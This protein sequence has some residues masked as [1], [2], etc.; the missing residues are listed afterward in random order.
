MTAKTIA[1]SA[2]LAA[3]S[4]ILARLIVPMPNAYTRF[5]LEAAP[6]FLAGV[7]FG[8]VAGSM[9]GFVADLVGTLFSGF[10][11]NP[12]LCLPPILY[13]LAGGLFRKR[14]AG[15]KWMPWLA[16]GLFLPTAFG[17]VLWQSVPLSYFYMYDSR[18]AG[19]FMQG[20]VF[21]LT[22]RGIQFALTYCANLLL[23]AVLISSRIFQHLGLLPKGR[24]PG[25]I[26]DDLDAINYIHSISWKGSVPGLERTRELLR[27]MGDP[28]DRL[29]YIHVAGTNGKGS[30]CAMLAS[31]LHCAGYKVGM[32]TSPYIYRFHERM[33]IDGEPISPEELAEIT[34]QIRPLAESMADTPTEFELVSCIA[35]S[36]FAR[37]G[38]DIVVLE[39]GMGGELDSTNVIS[40]PEVA[41]IT[42]IGLDH[43]EYLGDTVEKIARTKAGICKQG[44]NVVLYRG[45]H[46]VETVIEQICRERGCTLRKAD[47]DSLRSISRDLSGQ[48]FDCGSKK[49]L[50]LPLLGEHQL[51]NA[52]V[53]LTVT[54]VLAENGWHITEDNVRDGLRCTVWP[55]RFDVMCRQPLFIVD[56]G[57]NPQCITALERNIR[58]YLPD[59]EI[60]VLTG[61]LAD[62]DYKE[63]FRPILPL[64]REFVCITPP[65]PR[66]LDSALLAQYL[67]E[68]GARACACETVADGVRLAAEKAG[69]DGAVLCFGSL[70]SI[71]QI[72][73]ALTDYLKS[74]QEGSQC[75]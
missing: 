56:G 16:L 2:L 26:R 48:V 8:P 70:Y 27:K 74:L 37:H 53:A 40:T 11:Y 41:V 72:R 38:C 66:K 14:I 7:L 52:A 35:F 44:G 9:V 5:S 25:K 21:F 47:F 49:D 31:I 32:Y 23:C 17:S 63:M 55:G 10:G 36:Y 60:V 13:G 3:V 50:F 51:C 69:K 30:T 58:E 57:H 22:T 1:G 46:S 39:V 54:D 42:N 6:I 73:L 28:Q 18:V 67:Q 64:V 33:Q 15:K 65:N 29:K 34:R 75:I 45:P 43:T 24:K 71:G 61:V 62:K 59:R 4:V 19:S 68:T 20:F 12:F